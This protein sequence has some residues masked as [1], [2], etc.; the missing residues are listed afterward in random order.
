MTVASLLGVTEM[1]R[2]RVMTHPA[3]RSPFNRKERRVCA[4]PPPP[5]LFLVR[6][7]FGVKHQDAS[8][9]SMGS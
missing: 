8:A 2:R 5:K 9:A 1:I 3:P 7:T 6:R 4:P